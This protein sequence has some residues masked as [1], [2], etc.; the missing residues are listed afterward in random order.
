[1]FQ[2]GVRK[3]TRNLSGASGLEASISTCVLTNEAG[4]MLP[5]VPEGNAD[6]GK[7]TSAMRSSWT[8][9]AN[10]QRW[11]A[12]RECGNRRGCELPQ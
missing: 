8:L 12:D 7:G 4:D 2:E 3:I 1:M 9:G 11:K 10:M 6:T 5:A